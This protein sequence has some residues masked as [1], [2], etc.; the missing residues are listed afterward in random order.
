M[1]LIFDGRYRSDSQPL[2]RADNRSLRYGEGLFETIQMRG[3]VPIL[4]DR[5]MERLFRGASMLELDVP[6]YLSTDMLLGYMKELRRKNQT[7]ELTRIRVTFLKGE[8]GLYEH[9]HPPF[10]FMVQAWPLGR[11]PH[12]LNEAGFLVD[13][14]PHAR[15]SMDM[16][17][18]LKM[19]NYLP[20]AMAA[21]WARNH[22]LNDALLLNAS[23]RLAESSIANLFAVF[24]KDLVTPAL[25]EGCIAGVTRGFLLQLLPEAGF[26]VEETT[27]PITMLQRADALFLC[28][29]GYGIR[30][31]EACQGTVFDRKPVAHVH[32]LLEAAIR[33]NY[34]Y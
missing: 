5:H 7:G 2:I 21:S 27:M 18:N 6:S 17:S 4:L 28:N 25:S 15:L 20:Y 19:N 29:A 1:Q 3:D 11:N 14:Y 13:V 24:G 30:W 12:V 34:P 22:Q 32:Q 26:R 16:F 10:H 23:E 31:V 9:P 8:G 33:I